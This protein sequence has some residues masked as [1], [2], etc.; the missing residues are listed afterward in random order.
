M[1]NDEKRC[2]LKLTVDLEPFLETRVRIVQSLSG[3]GPS[4]G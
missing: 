4:P 2:L 1:V 3:A